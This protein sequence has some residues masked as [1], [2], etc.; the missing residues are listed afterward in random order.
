MTSLELLSP[1][2]DLPTG[3]AAISCGADAVYIGGPKFGARAA[4]GNPIADIERL[5]AYAHRYSAKVYMVINTILYENEIADAVAIA[6][7]A[8]NAG[9]DALII[10]DFGLLETNLPPIPLFASTQT[11]N[12]TPEKVKFLED[13]GFSRVILA[14]ELNLKQISDIRQATTVPLESFVHGALCV[15][16]SGQCYLSHALTGRSANRGTC[17][18]PCRMAYNLLD[19]KGNRIVKNQH[20]LSLRDL[21]LSGHIESLAQAGISSFKIEGRLKDEGYVKNVVS[22]YRSLI[23][24]VVE[25]SGSFTKASSGKPIT[26][27]ASDPERSFSR[28]FTTYFLD[29]R[30][31][32]AS[33]FTPKSVGKKLGVVSGIDSNSFTI[34]TSEKVNNG[35]GI[36]F[37][38]NQELIGTNI[39]KVEGDHLFPNSMEGIIKGSEIFRNFDKAFADSLNRDVARKVE[40]SISLQVEGSLTITAMDKDG[41]KTSIVINDEITQATNPEKAA[42]TWIDQ[43][44]KSGDS[45]FTVNKVDIKTSSIPF[46][47]VGRINALR[48]ELLAALE[49]KRVNSYQRETKHHTQTQHP[50]PEQEIKFTGNVVNSFARK[51]F[52]R[53]GCKVVQEGYELIDATP[54][55]T[56]MTTKYCL[57][58]EMGDCLKDRAPKEKQLPAKLFLE[59]NGKNLALEF[60]CNRCEM[61]IKLV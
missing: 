54:G 23:D 6:H 19:E 28:G 16:Y 21:N 48:R 11:N 60:D 12:T 9:V 3:I 20:L 47:Q 18:Q 59:N 17:A 56:V 43:L 46:L 26:A 29:N 25:K 41:I 34:R 4:V 5:A 42:Q 13:A 38:V 40:A 37:F 57:R 58:Y 2:K 44:S 53:H 31:E 36:C 55:D 49:E 15:S 33:R 35:D 30:R 24:K 14:R 8:W 52:E 61:K 7:Q 39:N 45:M 51:F 27:F 50:Y 1:A 22:H 32:M 10:Q